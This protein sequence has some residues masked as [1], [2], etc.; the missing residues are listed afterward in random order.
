MAGSDHTAL[1]VTARPVEGS[2]STRR[3]RKQG[4]VALLKHL[5][6]E[7]GARRNVLIESNQ[8]GRTEGFTLVRFA[9]AVTPGE[10]VPTTIAGHDGKALLAA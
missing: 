6:E 4:E 1:E 2:R 3:L 5:S 8:L 7:V 10:I 9:K